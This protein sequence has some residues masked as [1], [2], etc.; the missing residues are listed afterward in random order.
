MIEISIFNFLKSK[1]LNVFMEVPAQAP[2]EFYV[3]EKTGS[4]RTEHINE[5]TFAL[6]SYGETMLRAAQMSED[7]KT[8]LEQLI[9]LSSVSRVSAVRDYN[10]TDPTTKKYRYQIVFTIIHY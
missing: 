1:G 10:Y 9:A 4:S 5:S 6:Q 3:L 7:A 2:Q 8:I